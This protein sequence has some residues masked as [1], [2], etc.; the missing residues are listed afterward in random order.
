MSTAIT[1]GDMPT[2]TA[3]LTRMLGVHHNHRD[4]SQS[5]LVLDKAAELRKGPA[6]HTSPLRLPER[7]P[8][9]DAFE[10]FEGDARVEC[11]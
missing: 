11:L 5:C 10:V 4:T 7:S 6:G 3:L 8:L 9:A 1:P 2:G